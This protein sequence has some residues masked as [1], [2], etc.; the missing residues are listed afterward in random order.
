MYLHNLTDSREAA[1]RLERFFGRLRGRK[2]ETDSSEDIRTT[3]LKADGQIAIRMELTD[4][5]VDD[6]VVRD[7]VVTI[8]LAPRRHAPH[9]EPARSNGRGAKWD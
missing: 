8:K 1:Q 3:M 7:D 9:H 5:E 6:I 2:R 4:F